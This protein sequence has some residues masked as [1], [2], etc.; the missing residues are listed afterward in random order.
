MET[1]FDIFEI[2]NEEEETV[3]VEVPNSAIGEI[4]IAYRNKNKITT[5]KSGPQHNRRSDMKQI[6]YEVKSCPWVSMHQRFKRKKKKIQYLSR[7]QQNRDRE[8][9]TDSNRAGKPASD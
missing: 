1:R 2:T 7:A 9:W 8:R 4:E 6:T 5:Q 3:A